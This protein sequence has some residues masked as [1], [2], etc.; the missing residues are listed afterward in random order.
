MEVTASP[1]R[2]D[3]NSWNVF[4][5]F[6]FHLK[7]INVNFIV[8]RA[9]TQLK[10]GV[11]CFHPMHDSEDTL[12]PAAAPA[13][14]CQSK[15]RPCPAAGKASSMHVRCGM[16]QILSLHRAVGSASTAMAV[17][18]STA[19]DSSVWKEKGRRQMEPGH[20]PEVQ[21][22]HQHEAAAAFCGVQ[23]LKPLFS[24]NKQP[25]KATREQAQAGHLPEGRTL[26]CQ[27]KSH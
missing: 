9:V 21:S 19:E 10:E 4:T 20:V 2:T 3:Y 17:Q 11:S 25:S 26:Y 8:G 12:G 14:L 24:T 16:A 22:K 13:Q 1:E 15:V 6:S 27:V 5:M 23:N 18:F 7:V